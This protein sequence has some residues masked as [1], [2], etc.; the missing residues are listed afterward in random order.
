MSYSVEWI[1]PIYDRTYGDVIT[2]EGQRQLINPKGCYNAIDLNRIEN[3]TKYVMESMLEKS[4]IRTPPALAIKLNWR[5]TDI[6][7]R[8]DMARII[9]NIRLLMDLSNPVVYEQF[10]IIYESTQ[11]TYTLANAIERNLDIMRT[12]PELPVKRWLLK[13]VNGTILEY[14]ASAAYVAEHETVTIRAMASGENAEFMEF[15]HWS[16]NADDLQY[17]TNVNVQTTTYQMQYHDEDSYEVELTATFKIRIPRTLKLNGG[18]IYDDIGGSTRQFF[19]GDNILILANVATSGKRFYGWEGTQAAVDNLTG[20]PEP[21]TS[22]LVMPD[23]DVELTSFYINAGQHSVSIDGYVKGWYD[24]NDTVELSAS[25]PGSKY[26]FSHW[27]GD[28]AYLESTSSMSFKMPDVNV[29]LWSNWTYVP[30][31]YQLVVNNGSG[32]GIYNDDARVSIIAN[33]PPDGTGFY[34]WTLDEG[35]GYIYD[36][37]SKST[38]FYMTTSNA[39]ITAHFNPIRSVILENVNNSGTSKTMEIIEGN[40]YV[41]NTNEVSG[42]KIF[43]Y[44]LADNGEKISSLYFTVQMGSKDR[45]YTAVYTDRKTV[46]LTVNNGSGSG[47]Y[48]EKSTV[49]ITADPAPAGQRFSHWSTS[50]DIYS[51]SNSYSSS[52]TVV[53]GYDDCSVTA[54]YEDIPDTPVYTYYTLTVNNGSGGGSYREGQ[55]VT[56]RGN[57]APST[58]EF[59]HWEENGKIISYQNPYYFYMPANNR[60]ITAVYKPI[61]YFTVTVIN[62]TLEN[63]AT[64]GTFI[65]NSNPK[66]IM[67]PAPEG[68]KFL[69]WEVI[70]GDTNTVNEPLAETTYIRN[71]VKDVTVKAT[72][73]VP[74]PEITYTLTIIDKYGNTKTSNHTVGETIQIEADEPDEG[75]KFFKWIGDTQYLIDRYTTP[76]V[77]NMPARNITIEMEYRMEGYTTTYHVIIYGG[78]LLV[79]ADPDTGE[80]YWDIEGEF[81]ER[82]KVQI[83]ATDIPLGWKFNGWKNDNDDG[84]SVST[85][86][87]IMNDNTFLIVE[88]FDIELTRDV[89]EKDK[90]ELAITGGEISGTY[91]V[92]DPVPIY[93]YIPGMEDDDTRQY[94]F[95]RW[96]GQTSYL[97]LFDGGAPFDITVPGTADYPQTVKMPTRNISISAVYTT[98]YSLS[99]NSEIKDYYNQGD[100]IQLSAEEFEGKRFTYWT[101]DVSAVDNAYNPNITVT[102]PNKSI[103]LIPNYHNINDNNYVGYSL[104]SL[105]NND[106]INIEDITIISGELSPGFMITDNDGHIYVATDVVGNTAKIVRLTTVQGGDESGQ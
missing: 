46:T 49:S 6:P 22:W 7:T 51:I 27:S 68:M 17:V 94:T 30:E 41:V 34:N 103:N 8:E 39:V 85:V 44:W 29:S 97:K 93:F 92:G 32:S 84:K 73:Y 9:N 1:N 25:S 38:Y 18:R 82:T 37:D 20:G 71:L 96:S 21:S 101:G 35:S 102:M 72:Y 42:N 43:D 87:E 58:Y 14:N 95:V 105:S 19:P 106:T 60:T 26:V 83:R 33:N 77:V 86:N 74:D 66:I 13:I 3:N 15:I 40:Y 4:I 70:V 69:Q 78:E 5:E 79:S 81:E 80:E 91:Y 63:G 89:I 11:F 28:T 10:D 99:V 24:Y 57:Q 59:S 52:T 2:A 75:Y 53:V 12:Q 104:T 55:Y 36:T 67:D 31:K 65:R 50:W 48:L 54:I 62:G 88:D 45:V 47:E 76:T 100:K 98:A 16:G 61:P 23:C 90:K 56:C 64:S